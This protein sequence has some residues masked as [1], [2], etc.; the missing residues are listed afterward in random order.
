MR[1]AFACRM[2]DAVCLLGDDSGALLSTRVHELAVVSAPTMLLVLG[3]KWAAQCAV[4]ISVA[5]T[6]RHQSNLAPVCVALLHEFGTLGVVESPELRHCRRLAMLEKPF[7]MDVLGEIARA[8][9]AE[10]GRLSEPSEQAG[11]AAR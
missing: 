4:P 7:E 8:A 3:A 9:R 1:V 5:A 10:V 6:M 11:A 2:A